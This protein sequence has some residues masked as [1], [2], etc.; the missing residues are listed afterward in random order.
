MA[1]RATFWAFLAFLSNFCMFLLCVITYAMMCH[2]DMA[3]NY[4]KVTVRSKKVAQN[5]QKVALW[6]IF[7][8]FLVILTI[9]V[10][11][12]LLTLQWHTWKHDLNVFINISRCFWFSRPKNCS[13]SRKMAKNGYT[14]HFWRFFWATRTKIHKLFFL[15][16]ELI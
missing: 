4:K 11:F 16:F 6:A 2:D 12:F 1:R 15:D 7:G 10:H 8:C 3:Q 9:S 13:K 14:S 5:G